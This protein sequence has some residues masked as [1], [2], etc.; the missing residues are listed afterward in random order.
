MTVE[1]IVRDRNQ[2][3]SNSLGVPMFD[4]S[5]RPISI[6]KGGVDHVVFAFQ[7]FN[8]LRIDSIGGDER[9]NIG[10]VTNDMQKKLQEKQ[11]SYRNNA[12]NEPIQN[13]L[14]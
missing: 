14:I 7:L 11:K 10:S 4:E 2:T 12:K 1:E 5:I 6:V 3:L 9:I 8:R 13:F